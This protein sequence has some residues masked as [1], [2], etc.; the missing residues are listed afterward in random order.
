M[1][2]KRMDHLL[3]LSLLC[4]A[5]IGMATLYA[6]VHAGDLS[7][8]YKQAAYWLVGMAGFLVMC[9]LPLRLVGLMVWPVY[10]LALLGL[11]L[12]PIIG[13]VHMGAR[14]WLD[15]GVVNIQPSELMKWVLI[16]VLAHWF[17]MREASTVRDLSV[18][19][20]CLAVPAGLIVIQPDLGTALVMMLAAMAMVLVA[21]FPW[22]WFAGMVLASPLGLYV[23]WQYMHDY[24]KTRVLSFLHP[25]SDPLGAGYHVI[26]ASIAIGSGGMTG[27][28]YLE[29]S[30]SR[31]HFLPEQHTDFI[32]AV[33]AE[34]GGLVAAM[35]LFAL[36]ALLLIRILIIGLQAHSRFGGLICVGVAAIFFL[37]VFVNIGMV[38]GL[39]PVVGVPLPFVSY[40]GSAL[41]SMLVALGLVMRVAIES[42]DKVSWQ[43]PSSPLS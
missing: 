33:L 12:V 42:K 24:Q 28:G 32:F 27:K 2:F 35:V 41:L 10:V 43:R 15:L 9:L 29:G 26:Q 37:Y 30:Q 4:I 23:L 1:I 13:D 3:L 8:W 18:A 36:Y 25:E 11:A 34:E 39:L 31:L 7:V 6:A 19:L 40:G 38:S 22:K 21:G 20:L 16:L 5:A 17:A 14:R